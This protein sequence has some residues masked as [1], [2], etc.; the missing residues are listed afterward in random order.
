MS[1]A[2]LVHLFNELLSMIIYQL[3]LRGLRTLRVRVL[4]FVPRVCDKLPR[5]N[6]LQCIRNTACS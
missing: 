1:L 2:A 3:V 4:A 6:M 5:I